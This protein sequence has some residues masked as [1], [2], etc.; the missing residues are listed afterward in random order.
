M[1]G[2]Q[3]GQFERASDNYLVSHKLQTVHVRVNDATGQPTP[4]RVRFTDDDGVY[5]APLGRLTDFALA[6]F[7]G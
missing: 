3:N 7:L 1:V 4:V 6:T 5:Y 2:R